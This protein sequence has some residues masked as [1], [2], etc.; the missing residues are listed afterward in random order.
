MRKRSGSR[1]CENSSVL[2]R[3]RLVS[4]RVEHCLRSKQC[5]NLAQKR[6]GHWNQIFRGR[7]RKRQAFTAVNGGLLLSA[8]AL[9]MYTVR[10]AFLA[11]PQPPGGQAPELATRRLAPLHGRGR[12]SFAQFARRASL[13]LELPL[14]KQGDQSRAGDKQNKRECDANHNH[15]RFLCGGYLWDRDLFSRNGRSDQVTERIT[16]VGNVQQ[17]YQSTPNL[18]HI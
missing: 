18:R 3:S 10:T 5:A 7:I 4:L 9:R 14:R 13:I 6:L 12:E 11:R 1:S 8:P 17:Y 2:P 15:L 16:L